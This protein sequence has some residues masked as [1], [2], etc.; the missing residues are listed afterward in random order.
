MLNPDGVARG[1]HTLDALGDDLNRC[2]AAPDPEL[3]PQI[4]ALKKAIWQFSSNQKLLAFYGD[5]HAS[6]TFDISIMHGNYN[7][8]PPHLAKTMLVPHL[9][10]QNCLHFS[11]DQSSFT[12]SNRHSKRDITTGSARIELNKEHPYCM[13]IYSIEVPFLP[14]LPTENTIVPR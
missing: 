3:H 4:Y 10:Q 7:H 9:M 5:I 14:R 13:L 11:L 12:K 6:L 2:F 8:Y 1:N